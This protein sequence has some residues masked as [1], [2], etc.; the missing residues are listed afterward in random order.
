MDLTPKHTYMLS[1][2]AKDPNGT[3]S[4]E[5]RY[6]SGLD[7]VAEMADELQAHGYLDDVKTHE[8]S[9]DG[10]IDKVVIQISELGR[11]AVA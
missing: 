8:S 1:Q 10:R 6:E 3:G 7:E 11:Q 4:Y 2:A 5:R 9:R